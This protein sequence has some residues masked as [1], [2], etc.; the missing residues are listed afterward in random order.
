MEPNKCFQAKLTAPEGDGLPSD[1]REKD[2][3]DKEMHTPIALDPDLEKKA[4]NESTDA[5][6][7]E[8]SEL[9]TSDVSAEDANKE[10]HSTTTALPAEPEN[11]HD[12]NDIS[13]ISRWWLLPRAVR[14]E[15]CQESGGCV[16]HPPVFVPPRPRSKGKKKGK[17]SRRRQ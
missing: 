5:N 9:I 7:L 16:L 1:V 10:V 13:L 12:E 17:H 11:K 4:S 8:K 14:T 15:L 3:D 2:G 6:E